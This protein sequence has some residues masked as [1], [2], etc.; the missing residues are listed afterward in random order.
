M[1]INKRTHPT[2]FDVDFS[3]ESRSTKQLKPEEI[4]QAVFGNSIETDKGRQTMNDNVH[5]PSHYADHCSLECINAMAIMLGYEGTARYCLGNVFKYVWRH[6]FKNGLE[7]AKKAKEY[8]DIADKFIS[9]LDAKDPDTVRIK[10]IRSVLQDV[11]DQAIAE[12]AE[13]VHWKQVRR[14]DGQSK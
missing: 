9:K 5:H 12:Y 10:E 7:D 6:K 8:L 1:N 4:A 14:P 2:A 3:S 11:T 13:E